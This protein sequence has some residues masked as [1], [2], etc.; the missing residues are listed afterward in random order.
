MERNDIVHLLGFLNVSK[1]HCNETEPL[2]GWKPWWRSCP[3]RGEDSVGGVVM[4]MQSMQ[5]GLR[6]FWMDGYQN[7][8]L[9]G[10]PG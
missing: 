9:K 1:K 8:V 4:V 3:I 10:E 6:E 7:E 5:R 2:P